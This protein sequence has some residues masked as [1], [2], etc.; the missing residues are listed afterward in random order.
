MSDVPESTIS[1]NLVALTINK[2]S[3]NKALRSYE[4]LL[5]TPAGFKQYFNLAIDLVRISYNDVMQCA[6]DFGAMRTLDDQL[7]RR[8]TVRIMEIYNFNLEDHSHLYEFMQSLL[9]SELME[10]YFR[11]LQEL[12]FIRAPSH[13]LD[14]AAWLDNMA[15]WYLVMKTLRIPK[16]SIVGFSA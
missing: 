3:R 8:N 1:K 15:L 7:I 6:L 13:D 5:H 9:T 12:K 4:A 16:I 11:A 14:E 10:Q 2:Q